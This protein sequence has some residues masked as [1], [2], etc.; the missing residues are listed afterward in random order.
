MKGS[1]PFPPDIEKPREP[2]MSRKRVVNTRSSLLDETK[3]LSVQEGLCCNEK[4]TIKTNHH[5]SSTVRSEMGSDKV[6]RHLPHYPENNL[7]L[8]QFFFKDFSLFSGF[9]PFYILSFLLFPKKSRLIQY[10]LSVPL[11]ERTA[12]ILI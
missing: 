7:G 4:K 5:K 11:S 6:L 8:F 10:Q 3:E 9:Q 12:H 2:F 1:A